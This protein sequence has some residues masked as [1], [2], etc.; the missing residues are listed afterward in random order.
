MPWQSIDGSQ[1]VPSFQ[2][3]QECS[4]A[5]VELQE[6]QTGELY[7][8]FFY[9]ELDSRQCIQTALPVSVLT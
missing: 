6:K 7:I 1:T 3:G 8:Y 9:P 4:V 2:V 5:K